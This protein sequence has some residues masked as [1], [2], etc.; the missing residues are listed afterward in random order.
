LNEGALAKEILM[1]QKVHSMP[2][3]LRECQKWIEEYSLPDIFETK[4]TKLQ[5]KKMIKA[6]I[7]Q[8]NEKELKQKMMGLDKLKSSDLVTEEFGVRPYVK[9]LTVYQARNIFKKRSSMMRDVK[10]NYMSDVKN[11]A[12]MWLCSSCQTSIDSM[13]HVLWCP[14]Y[15]HLRAEK[16]LHDDR[17]LA[18]YLH[19]VIMIRNK[20][21]I[22][23]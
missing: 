3:L 9:N 22:D 18:N 17:D 6:K 11:V 15:Q 21:D 16:D 1:V 7:M 8:Q 4:L 20:L 13:G 12:S 14:S 2:G 5:W 19:D 10:M 23:K